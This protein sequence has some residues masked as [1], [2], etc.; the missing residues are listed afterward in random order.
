TNGRNLLRPINGRNQLLP[1]SGRSLTG[2]I[3]LKPGIGPKDH[4][5]LT[6]LTDGLMVLQRMPPTAS[7][8]GELNR[9][10]DLARQQQ[11]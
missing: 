8:P 9:P 2:L 7:S 6:G 11:M 4:S 1:T 5:L 10:A 3:G